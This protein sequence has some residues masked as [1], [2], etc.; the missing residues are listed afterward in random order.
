MRTSIG[1]GLALSF[2][3]TLSAV[4]AH[5]QVKAPPCIGNLVNAPGE[6]AA[7]VNSHDLT[8]LLN[9]FGAKITKKSPPLVAAA[10]LNSDGVVD[11]ADLGIQL[12]SY[13]VCP[14][15]CPGDFN[16]DGAI[17]SVDLGIV[18]SGLSQDGQTFV[19]NGAKMDGSQALAQVITNWGRS[20]SK[21][22]GKVAA[23]SPLAQKISSKTK[24]KAQKISSKTKAK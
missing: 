16:R 10:D 8:A 19:H 14:S 9:V 18:L 13:G 12:S 7:V 24:A 5:A 15:S 1:L 20:C 3:V 23:T 22:D 11:G 17:N 2:V 4:T 6:R 21:L